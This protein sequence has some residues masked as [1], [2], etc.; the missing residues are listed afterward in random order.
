MLLLRRI[1]KHAAITVLPEALF[2]GLF[3]VITYKPDSEFVHGMFEKR[4]IQVVFGGFA[5]MYALCLMY[6]YFK[7]IA[8]KC[9]EP[10]QVEVLEMQ[11]VHMRPFYVQ[12]PHHAPPGE[13]LPSN[14]FHIHEE[15]EN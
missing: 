7:L 2:L 14:G 11:P 5:V 6:Y 4:A 1:A 9:R 8:E 3:A 15:R 13:V 12:F 10:R